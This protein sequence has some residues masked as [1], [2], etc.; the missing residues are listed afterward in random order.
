MREN[1]FP[2]KAPSVGVGMMFSRSP[3]D[4]YSPIFIPPPLGFSHLA[5][6]APRSSGAI[7][8]A[9][10]ESTRATTAHAGRPSPGIGDPHDRREMLSMPY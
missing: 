3:G 1:T 2:T 8:P 9:C 5:E 6:F 10:F 7:A 4:A